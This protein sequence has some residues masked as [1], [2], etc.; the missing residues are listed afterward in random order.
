[1]QK[2]IDLV[3]KGGVIWNFIQEGL[4]Q[5][6]LLLQLLQKFLLLILYQLMSM[7]ILLHDQKLS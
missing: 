7:D 2:I 1:M 6:S 3:F 4:L 5:L